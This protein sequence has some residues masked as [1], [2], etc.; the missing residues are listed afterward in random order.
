M[1]SWLDVVGS[2]IIGGFIIL[3]VA[4]LNL[5]ITTSS[6]EILFSNIAQYELS[7]VLNI[8]EQDFSKIGYKA[9]GDKISLAKKN[10]IKF[11]ADIDDNGSVETVHYYWGEKSELTSTQN[12]N[13]RPLYRSIDNETGKTIGRITDF[14][15]SYYD[16]S[17]KKLSYS[18]LENASTRRKIKSIKIYLK[19]ESPEIV[20]SLYHGAEWRR[21]LSPKNL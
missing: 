6:S 9:S 8:A 1:G 5:A 17:S 16:S 14:T 10:E 20:D 11:S 13:D 18:S 3:I 15:L 7:S 19:V 4:N 21:K 12:P 2:I